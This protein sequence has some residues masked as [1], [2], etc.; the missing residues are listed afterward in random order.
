[1]PEFLYGIGLRLWDDRRDR[2]GLASAAR[3]AQPEQH[4]ADDGSNYEAV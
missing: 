1:M 4:E 3:P 2:P